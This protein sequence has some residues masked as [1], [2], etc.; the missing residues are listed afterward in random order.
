MRRRFQVG[1]VFERG[2]TRKCWVARY[3]EPKLVGGEVQRVLRSRVIGPV[4]GMT[5]SAARTV[6]ESWL[7]PLNEGL[8][9]PIESASF[10][11]FY[12]KWERD[13][14][15]TYR[16]STRE[17]Y[18]QTAKR[19]I[20][21]YFEDWMMSQ[22]HPG[23]VQRFIN[24]F[25][26]KYSRSVLKHVRATLRCLFGAALDW[27]YVRENPTLKLRIPYGRAVERAKVIS[28]DQIAA[29]VGKLEEPFRAM[30]MLAATSAL[31]ESELFGLQWDDFDW[32]QAKIHVR[33]RVYRRRVGDTKTVKSQREIPLL[34]EVLKAVAA[35]PHGENQF[36]FGGPKGG[37]LRPDEIMQEHIRPAALALGFPQI[38]WRSFRRSAESYMHNDGV[39][40][41]VQQAMLGHTNPNTTLLYAEADLGMMRSAVESLGRRIFPNLSQYATSKTSGLVN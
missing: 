5:K 20:K 40:L 4:K 27:Q 31:R 1:H 29:L 9:V 28:L 39:P 26:S 15:P 23:E 8:Y 41:K 38:T 12:E 25:A 30:V 2:K 33:R 35:L 32:N 10:L 21:P 24:T 7:R 11:E 36:I 14:L 19:W 34:D 13:L 22:I 18:R 16:E 17:F 6:L 3:V 37:F